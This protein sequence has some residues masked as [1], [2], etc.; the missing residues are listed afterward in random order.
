VPGVTLND[1]VLAVVAGALRDWMDARGEHPDKPLTAGVPV[2]TDVAGGPLR[3]GGNRVSNLF[4]C[5]HTDIDDPLERLQ[6]IART[7]RA[8]KDVQAAL[9]REMLADWSQFAPPGP[10]SAFM[11]A[12]SRRRGA[13]RHPAPFNVVVSNVPGPTQPISFGGARMTEMFSVGPILE[14]I[15]LNLTWWSYLDRMHVGLLSCPDVVADLH[16]LATRL[17]PALAALQVRSE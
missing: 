12:Y 9:G 16:P 10:L 5:L 8:A 4:T 6:A 3:L 14:G 17:V 15:A 7:T 2:G 13:D 11:R 1:V